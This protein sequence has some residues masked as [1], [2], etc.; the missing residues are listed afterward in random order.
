MFFLPLSTLLAPMMTGPTSWGSMNQKVNQRR[1]SARHPLNDVFFCCIKVRYNL[2]WEE[3]AQIPGLHFDQIQYK[4]LII[5]YYQRLQSQ[6]ALYTQTEI[7]RRQ[8][9]YAYTLFSS[10]HSSSPTL[11]ASDDGGSLQMA[12]HLI[13][14]QS[15]VR[16]DEARATRALSIRKR[17]P[18]LRALNGMEDKNGSGKK[19]ICRQ[20]KR[21]RERRTKKKVTRAE[22]ADLA[23]EPCKLSRGMNTINRPLAPLQKEEK[24]CL[25]L[26]AW[27]GQHRHPNT[28]SG[29][30]T[31]PELASTAARQAFPKQ[32]PPF[33][34]SVP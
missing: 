34:K 23:C 29:L 6:N 26:P 17:L 27:C 25:R 7:S 30:Y 21:E 3:L 28:L 20:N 14:A 15:R 24:N 19:Y 16:S 9:I 22:D 10:Q 5:L 4:G 11:G 32:S 18:T 31:F 2:C 8:A 1:R 33:Q 12:S 13:R